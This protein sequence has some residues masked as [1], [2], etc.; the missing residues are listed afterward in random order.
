MAS[1]KSI[2]L[3]AQIPA[4]K[5]TPTTKSLMWRLLLKLEL[6]PEVDPAVRQASRKVMKR[7]GMI[8][9]DLKWGKSNLNQRKVGEKKIWAF[10]WMRLGGVFDGKG[11][12]ES[13]GEGGG[14]GWGG[15]GGMGC[16]GCREGG[17]LGE[18]DG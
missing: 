17:G 1:S 8:S 14:L 15:W 3:P 2:R 18:E 5:W 4:F 9:A 12:E 7:W 16:L 13:G 11:G 6:M 10:V